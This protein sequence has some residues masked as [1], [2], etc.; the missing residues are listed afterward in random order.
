MGPGCK[1]EEIE[2]WLEPSIPDFLVKEEAST[3]FRTYTAAGQQHGGCS[4]TRCHTYRGRE[5]RRKM[6]SEKVLLR[7]LIDPK[8]I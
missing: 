5:K 2:E 4:H 3:P 6:Q 1:I 8:N 7:G